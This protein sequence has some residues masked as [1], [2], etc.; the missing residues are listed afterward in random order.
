MQTE[1]DKKHLTQREQ[2][3]K[4]VEVLNTVHILES[5]AL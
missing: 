2:T 5:Q 1:L 4:T 3:E